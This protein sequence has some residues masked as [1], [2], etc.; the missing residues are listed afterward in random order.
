MLGRYK[1]W[2]KWGDPYSADT[3]KVVFKKY[4]SEDGKYLI[5]PRPI[6]WIR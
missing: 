2:K 5:F 6:M 3:Y 4:E 1:Y